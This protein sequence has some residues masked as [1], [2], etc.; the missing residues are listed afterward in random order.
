MPHPKK[1]QRLAGDD[2][3]CS[4]ETAVAAS[5][6]D[7][8]IDVLAEIFGF[9]GGAKNIFGWLRVQEIMGK[10]CVCKKWKEAVKKTIVPLADFIVGRME[11]YNAMNVMTRALPN[12][13]QIKLYTFR[14]YYNFNDNELEHHKYNDGEDPDEEEAARAADWIAHD[15]EIISNFSKLR[16]LYIN[17]ADLN[18][19]YPV[20]FNF[21]Q[22]KK[23]SIIDCKHLKWDLEMLAGLPLLKELTCWT[24]IGLT[25]NI[26]S[27]RVLK[28]TLEKVTIDDCDHVEGNFMDL[29]DFPHLKELDLDG[30]AV[31]GD[32][33]DIGRNDFSLLEELD[34][35]KGVYGGGENEFQ[36]IADGPDVVRAVYLLKKQRPALAIPGTWH[37]RLSK[38]SPD[39]YESVDEDDDDTPFFIKFVEAGP[40]I[41]Y[42]WQTRYHGGYPCEV[43]WLDPEPDRESSDYE[44]YIEDL[45]EIERDVD[46]YKGFHQPPT[47]EEYEALWEEYRNTG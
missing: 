19:R 46:F 9:L 7:L 21:P 41:G 38:E 20:L 10:R 25:G 22:L 14:D 1:K 35:P 17:C 2:T 15:I 30:T 31:I 47:E 45:Q 6:N 24:N 5:A 4:D 12:L 16:I 32:I 28:D 43:N 33:R 42:R 3:S 11:G 18:G 37:V 27:L 13:Q 34:L 8:T 39:W 44:E 23:L 40:R 29:A 36:R 26:S